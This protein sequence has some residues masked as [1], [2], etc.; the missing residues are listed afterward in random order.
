MHFTLV[1]VNVGG[2]IPTLLEYILVR[3]RLTTALLLFAVVGSPLTACK[4]TPAPAP[5]GHKSAASSAPTD[6]ISWVIKIDPCKSVS[7]ALKG[8]SAKENKANDTNTTRRC[9]FTHG[10]SSVT[11][12]VGGDPQQA[13]YDKDHGY[14]SFPSAKASLALRGLRLRSKN[15]D[16]TA[17]FIGMVDGHYSTADASVKG[18]LVKVSN[19]DSPHESIYAGILQAF[20]D[21]VDASKNG[22]PDI[23]GQ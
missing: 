1:T 15:P 6:F 10:A 20:A 17:A 11:V 3:S 2:H 16:H 18:F 14:Y 8:W 12:T 7:S 21:Y 4:A 19:A 5:T 9:V 23:S 22:I 13:S